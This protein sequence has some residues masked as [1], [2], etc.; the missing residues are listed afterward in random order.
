MPNSPVAWQE[1][2]SRGT[3]IA[4]MH[5][6]TSVAEAL[7]ELVDNAI[8]YRWGQPLV[9]EI[10]QAL[11]DV[12]P[13]VAAVKDTFSQK[14]RTEDLSEVLVAA[15]SVKDELKLQEKAQRRRDRVVVE[16]HGGRGM[17][18]EEIQV[19][20]NW[21]E[22]EEHDSSHIGRWHQGGKAACGFLGRHVKLWA[23]R[24]GSDDVWFLEDEDWNS[25]REPK[26]FGVPEPLPKD[27]DPETMRG[28][29]TD[30]GHVRIEVAKLVKE[31]RWNLETLKRDLS[32]T[33]RSLLEKG[34]VRIRINGDDVAALDISLSTA[35][36]QV[37][38]NA[39]LPGGRTVSGWAGR[40]KRDQL[41]A[42]VKAGLRLVHNGRVIKAGEWFGYNYEGKGALN[43]LIGELHMRGFTPVPNKTDFVDRG[44]KV[45]EELGRE[46]L[47]QLGPLISELRK[48][49]E[50]GRVSK[51]DKQR[52]R[53]VADELEKVF[54]SLS[55]MTE[56]GVSAENNGRTTEAGPGGRKKAEPQAGRTP[57]RNP[58]G[59][60]RNPRKP[61]TEPPEDPVGT[62]ARLLTK[63]T[64][65][66]TRPPLRIRSWDPSERSAW[67][68]E[69]AKVWL[70][71]NN[72]YH[73]YQSLS[74]AKPYLAET[75]ILHL[76]TPS[77]GEAMSAAQYLERVN[78]MLLK[79]A[80]VAAGA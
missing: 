3:A 62:I 24:A 28:L 74:G 21:G 46:V 77:E 43:S 8:D 59:P 50:E 9:I 14:V 54:V 5:N 49:G 76:C 53:E 20:L 26:D 11:A 65:G 4:L 42:P 45:W 36:K 40:M 79:W 32:S 6:F 47:D 60:N 33:Y 18:A 1:T 13:K 29:A 48:S 57:V 68:T 10:T 72:T 56:V 22:G 70:D 19:W 25:R 44:D 66:D 31:R 71:I 23:K 7:K 34:D 61:Q 69:G 63:V 38:I 2:I 30:E 52:A 55:E 51:E 35:V 64:G 39:K 37:P 41:S 78:L 12:E 27:Q 16:S 17:G 73:L 67:T 58:R 80:Q 75:A 15:K